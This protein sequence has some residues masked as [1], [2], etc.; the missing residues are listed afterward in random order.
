M[1]TD[2]L[3][4]VWNIVRAWLWSIFTKG[5]QPSRK[6]TAKAAGER[7]GLGPRAVSVG[8]D[9]WWT[10]IRLRK[11][12]L[13]GSSVH[14]YNLYL[15]PHWYHIWRSAEWGQTKNKFRQWYGQTIT[16]SYRSS[17]LCFDVYDNIKFCSQWH[18]FVLILMYVCGSLSCWNIHP[19]PFIR[20]HGRSVLKSFISWYLIEFMMPSIWTRCPS[21]ISGIK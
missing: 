5:V 20:F 12:T 8:V 3:T 16:V 1:V 21:R 15:L 10:Q 13:L 9:R 7:G 18:I 4:A 14:G 19:R 11:Q 17:L 2:V 6:V